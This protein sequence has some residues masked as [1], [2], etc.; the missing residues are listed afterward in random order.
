MDMDEICQACKSIEGKNYSSE[1]KKNAQ[2]N[3][4]FESTEYISDFMNDIQKLRKNK[5]PTFRPIDV[6]PLKISLF[7]SIIMPEFAKGI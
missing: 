7:K 1:K 6:R 3:D 5:A 4:S 2:E